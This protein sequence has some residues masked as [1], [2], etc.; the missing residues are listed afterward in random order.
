MVLAKVTPRHSLPVRLES[1]G[2]RKMSCLKPVWCV[3]PSPVPVE[4]P[5]AACGCC[6]VL[7]HCWALPNGQLG[8]GQAIQIIHLK[9]SKKGIRCFAM[10]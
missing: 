4:L 5:R 1:C 2:L 6:T 9:Y 3:D 8:H 7:G 10:T